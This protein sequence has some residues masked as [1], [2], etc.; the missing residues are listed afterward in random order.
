MC[1]N[2]S[3][4]EWYSFDSCE[5]CGIVASPNCLALRCAS[6]SSASCICLFSSCA[7]SS[8]MSDDWY[9]TVSCCGE[10]AIPPEADGGDG[11]ERR[12]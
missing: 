8:R 3:K 2:W 11:L 9:T 6:S 12:E 10:T 7:L 5:S 4:I 1:S